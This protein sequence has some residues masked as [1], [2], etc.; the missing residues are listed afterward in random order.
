MNYLD[1]IRVFFCQSVLIDGGGKL[2][3]LP[4]QDVVISFA[5][6]RANIKEKSDFIIELSKNVRGFINL[7][8][9][10]SPGLSSSPAIAEMVSE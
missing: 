10:E 8:G 9:I 7:A 1:N 6:L 4:Q 3:Y 5:G 2:P